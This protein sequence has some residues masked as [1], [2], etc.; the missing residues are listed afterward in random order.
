VVYC[1]VAELLGNEQAISLWNSYYNLLHKAG[2]AKKAL[3]EGMSRGG[4][5]VFNWA[6]V[7]PDKVAGVYVDNPLLNIPSWAEG[8]MKPDV[9][10]AMFEAFKKDYNLTTDDEIRA[11]KGSPVDKVKQIVKGKYPILILCA[12]EDEAVSPKDNTLLFEQKVKALNG[13]ITV[14]HKPGAKH[15]PHSLPN[16]EPIVDFLLKAAGY[17]I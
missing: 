16:P 8:M 9:K 2:L 6:A 4:V 3:M 15:H 14:I 17:G 12:D 13:N 5:Y 11:F 1:D 10:D 7:N